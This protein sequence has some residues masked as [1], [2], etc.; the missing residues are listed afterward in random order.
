MVFAIKIGF[1]H[2][3]GV[4]E[5]FNLTIQIAAQSGEIARKGTGTGALHAL[6]HAP[7]HVVAFG[8]GEDDAGPAIQKFA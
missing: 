3:Q 6:E 7:F 8:L 2:G 4:N 5:L 1:V